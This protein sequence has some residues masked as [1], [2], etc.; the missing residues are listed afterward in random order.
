M[1]DTETPE[2]ADSR[3]QAQQDTTHGYYLLALVAAALSGAAVGIAI[4]MVIG[5]VVL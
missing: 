1:S 3:M 4:G 5:A 2:R